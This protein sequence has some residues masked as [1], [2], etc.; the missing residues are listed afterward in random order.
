[1]SR[2]IVDDA[3]TCMHMHEGVGK[4]VWYVVIARHFPACR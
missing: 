1:M 3:V 4:Q 2:E